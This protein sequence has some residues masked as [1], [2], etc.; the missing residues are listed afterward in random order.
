MLLLIGSCIASTTSTDCSGL[1]YQL[2]RQCQQ[3]TCMAAVQQVPLAQGGAE[4]GQ[5]HAAGRAARAVALTFQLHRLP[6][7]VCSILFA[8]ALHKG[9]RRWS[10]LLSASRLVDR[11]WLPCHWLHTCAWADLIADLPCLLALSA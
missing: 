8:G 9:D 11:S 2:P 10:V 1:A 5:A 6:Q 7:V 3:H 4:G